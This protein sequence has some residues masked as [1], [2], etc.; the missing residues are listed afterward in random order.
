MRDELVEALRQ[1]KKTNGKRWKS[2]L[3]EM[4]FSGEGE[5]H[6]RELRNIVGPGGRRL[7]KI[8][9]TLRL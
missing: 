7:E 9:K 8:E 2:T 5:G 6:L 3:R 1:F 4:W